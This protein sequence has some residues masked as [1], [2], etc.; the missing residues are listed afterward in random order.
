MRPGVDYRNLYCVRGEEGGGVIFDCIHEID[1]L[2]WI[3]GPVVDISCSCGK[4]SDL[5]MDCEDWAV[6]ILT[7]ESG[8]RSEIHLDYL[9]RFKQRGCEIAGSEGTLQWRS[10][11]KQPEACSVRLYEDSQSSWS[12]LYVTDDEDSS[13][14]YMEMMRDF[15]S[16]RPSDRL[17]TFEDGA[18]AVEVA[19][20]ARVLGECC[21]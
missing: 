3:L 11:G 20:K 16:D 8:A 14:I 18:C 12:D 4:L 5:E 13:G 1:Y 9:Q 19:R 7:H 15:L 21:L 6:V 10:D 17:S 2:C